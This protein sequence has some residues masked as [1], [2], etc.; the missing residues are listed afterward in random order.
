VRLQEILRDDPYATVPP[1]FCIDSARIEAFL[2][3]YDTAIFDHYR[4]AIAQ[5]IKP[6]SFFTSIM[7]TIQNFFHVTSANELLGRDVQVEIRNAFASTPFVFSDSEEQLLNSMAESEVNEG[8]VNQSY[9]MVRSSGL[10]DSQT[11]ANAGLYRSIPYVPI[12]TQTGQPFQKVYLVQAMS[13]VVQSYFNIQAIKNNLAAGL[14]LL[15]IPLCIPIL[16]QKLIGESPGGTTDEKKIPI[17]GVAFTTNRLMGTDSFP[18]MEINAAYGH[19]EG[20][21][22]SRVAI[23]RYYITPS[24]TKSGTIDIYPMISYKRNRLVYQPQQGTLVQIAN[25]NL[26]AKKS[27]L[28]EEQLLQLYTVLKKIETAYGQPMDV[29]FVILEGQIYIVQARPAMGKKQNPSYIASAA[30]IGTDISEPV[31]GIVLVPGTAQVRIITNPQNIIV[32]NTLDEADSNA[33]RTNAEAVLV[34]TWASSLSH[35]AVNFMG[36]GTPC[37]YLPNKSQIVE[38]IAQI[39]PKT[40]L[41]VDVQRQQIFLWRNTQK[42]VEEV[43]QLGWY[44]H[45]IQRTLSLLTNEGSFVPQTMIQQPQDARL[46]SSMQTLKAQLGTPEQKG[47]FTQIVE[48]ITSRLTLTEKRMKHVG[49]LCDAACHHLFALFK[50]RILHLIDTFMVSMEQGADRFELLFY[51]KMLEALVYQESDKYLNAYTYRW[52]LDELFSAQGIYGY[53]TKKTTPNALIHYLRYCSVPEIGTYWRSVVCALDTQCATNTVPIQEGLNKL[54][55]LLADLTSID[56]VSMWFATTLYQAMLLYPQPNKTIQ[57]LLPYITHD[58]TPMAKKTM[59]MIAAYRDTIREISEQQHNNQFTTRRSV[60]IAWQTLKESLIEP[61]TS[62]IFIEQFKKSPFLIKIM[63]CTLMETVI[64]VI[65]STIKAMKAASN[66]PLAD[67]QTLFPIMLNDFFMLNRTW[68]TQIMPEGSI[69]YATAWPLQAYLTEQA[70]LFDQYKEISFQKS[71]TFSGQAAILGST[72]AFKR[73]L[74]KTHEDMF[75]LIHQNSLVAVSATYR[76]LFAGH[77]LDQL[78]YLPPLLKES[79]QEI[80]T[81]RGSPERNITIQN[82]GL[83]YTAEQ[84]TA[85]YNIP[86]NSH[87]ATFQLVY[88][89]TGDIAINVQFLG[90]ARHR[91]EDIAI[92]VALSPEL[93]QLTLEDSIILDKDSGIVSWSWQVKDKGQLI[94]ILMYIKRFCSI[95]GFGGGGFESQITKQHLQTLHKSG[96][97]LEALLQRAKRLIPERITGSQ[98]SQRWQDAL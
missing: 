87:S 94:I 79:M 84:I 58:Y 47:L 70:Q 9:V 55:A 85:S 60:E 29:E 95:A 27:A 65:D 62:D 26:I 36:L 33:A 64:D 12:T 18:V 53:G 22:A 83:R 23:D 72:T 89:S 82:I 73:H 74:P 35:A 81:W 8:S 38:L 66:I 68:L 67:R 49:N 86:L 1:F 59:S 40:P 46:I 96:G 98:L 15:N 52:F 77:P 93:A 6:T 43:I 14:Q 31:S 13:N 3:S 7:H 39:S 5:L 16:V 32:T 21:V 61:L 63:L 97:D 91:W 69:Q 44:E 50:Q 42:A 24:R 88:Q 25:D 28:D 57:E 48:R 37:L 19:G 75:M 90:Q 56:G 11:T 4:Q 17:S 20:I 54:H 10:E 76:S 92:L 71:S 45:P 34:G 30:V 51:H 41:L 80:E 2:S 78:I